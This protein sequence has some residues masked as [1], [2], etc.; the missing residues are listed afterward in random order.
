MAAGRG[1][2]PCP[3]DGAPSRSRP[4]PTAPAERSAPTPSLAARGRRYCRA[5]VA[6]PATSLVASAFLTEEPGKAA[7]RRASSHGDRQLVA[8][9]RV[10]LQELRHA[11]SDGFGALDVEEMA[12]ALDRELLDPW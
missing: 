7:G 10:A 1:H 2:A 8:G 12:D 5:N 11:A 9:D 6:V 4:R 3:G